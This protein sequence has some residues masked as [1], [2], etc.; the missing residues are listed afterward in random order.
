[1]AV[2][3][4]QPSW[5]IIYVFVPSYGEK[6]GINILWLSNKVFQYSMKHLKFGNTQ[7]Y[8]D[9]VENLFLQR[10]AFFTP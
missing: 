10:Y 6:K 1:M 5:H 7:S 4:N 3:K 8:K 2:K 9:P